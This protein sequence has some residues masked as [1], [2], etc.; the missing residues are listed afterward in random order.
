MTVEHDQSE[1]RFVVHHGGELSQLVYK[2]NK[3]SK[4][5]YYLHTEVPEAVQNQGIAEELVKE[6]LSFAKGEQLNIVPICP[7]VQAYIKRHPEYQEL[8]DR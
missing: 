2:R 7:Y 1:S 4:R 6:A 8:V 3:G 5:I